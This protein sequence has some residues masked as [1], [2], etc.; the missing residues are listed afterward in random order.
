MVGHE[1]KLFDLVLEVESIPSKVEASTK[2]I[3]FGHVKCLEEKIC[4]VDVLNTSPLNFPFTATLYQDEPSD[5]GD[6]WTI[7]PTSGELP[8]QSKVTLEIALVLKEVGWH[9]ANIRVL[10]NEPLKHTIDIKMKALGVGSPLVF[11]PV[12]DKSATLNFGTMFMQKEIEDTMNLWTYVPVSKGHAADDRTNTTAPAPRARDRGR[13]GQQMQTQNTKRHKPP[14]SEPPDL[15]LRPKVLHEVRLHAAF[16][17]PGL[18]FSKRNLNFIIEA[19]PVQEDYVMLEVVK[20]E[21]V[22]KLPFRV[23]IRT[24]FPFSFCIHND[25]EPME[26]ETYD[27]ETHQSII[28]KIQFD[29]R[30][31]RKELGVVTFDGRLE[32][33]Y[34][35]LSATQSIDLHG[36]V[37]FP[38]LKMDKN[39]IDFGTITNGMEAVEQITVTNPGSFCLTYKWYI[40]PFS[41]TVHR[42]SEP[43]WAKELHFDSYKPARNNHLM[44]L[45]HQ[46][47]KSTGQA[48]SP[49]K[50][51]EK[52]K[53]RSLSAMGSRDH[54]AQ[55]LG[56]NSGAFNENSSNYED[57]TQFI[58]EK[59]YRSRMMEFIGLKDAEF[60]AEDEVNYLAFYNQNA[61]IPKEEFSTNEIIDVIPLAGVVQ[62]GQSQTFTVVFYGH[63][64]ITF[65]TTL[66]LY[67][68]GGARQN[69]EV[70]GTTIH[71]T[72]ADKKPKTLSKTS[73]ESAASLAQREKDEEKR[74]SKSQSL[75]QTAVAKVQGQSHANNL[76][77]EKNSSMKFYSQTNLK[78]NQPSSM[79]LHSLHR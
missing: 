11:T 69:V 6:T 38:Q 75:S 19:T 59:M 24:K 60:E 58:K 27:F 78:Q 73:M 32:A 35:G 71:P 3:D 21:N 57:F 4:T 70:T 14:P 5:K 26:E 29:G 33:V 77:L 51:D 49:S 10:M 31:L 2:S 43:E 79:T 48:V 28:F 17:A 74:L 30:H 53:S 15:H 56:F 45:Q 9:Y 72:P 61:M 36:E 47:R 22:G 44:L 37:R 13:R 42:N 64:D 76:Q 63:P 62:A 8:S 52:R 34:E 67:I 25:E 20:I 12:M 50:M 54:F 39:L 16:E 46:K 65:K 68:E 66:V 23:K 7:Q 1:E 41:S 18:K 55:I 40:K